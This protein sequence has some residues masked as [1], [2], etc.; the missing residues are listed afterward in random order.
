MHSLDEDDSIAHTNY[1][2]PRISKPASPTSQKQAISSSNQ[3]QNEHDKGSKVALNQ[4]NTAASYN[5]LRNS[6]E[7][8]GQESE[9]EQPLLTR[10]ETS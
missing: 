2:S 1:N 7:L 4:N 10:T 3:L 5:P 8:P 9:Q 6:L